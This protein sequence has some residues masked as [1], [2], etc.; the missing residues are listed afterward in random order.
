MSC[1]FREPE[2]RLPRG[3]RRCENF[4]L[5][6]D[7]ARVIGIDVSPAMLSRAARR[8]PVAAAPVELREMDVTRLEFP[9]GYFDAA[10]TTFLF[11][12]LPDEL[13]LPALG[14]LRRVVKPGG[15][16]R[17]LEYVRP[18]GTIRRAITKL[19]EPWIAWLWSSIRSKPA[20]N[21]SRVV[22]DR[23]V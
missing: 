11:C 18:R 4:P 21:W 16:I 14:Q 23:R 10:V 5:Y 3:V 19:W 9:D 17:L 12:T 8:L 15:T 13:Q 22:S 2:R 20:S 1:S 7:S 6:P